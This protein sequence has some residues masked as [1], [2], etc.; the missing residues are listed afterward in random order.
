MLQRL[1]VAVLSSAADGPGMPDTVDQNLF[2]MF[3]SDIVVGCGFIGLG[4]ANVMVAV[5]FTLKSV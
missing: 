5:T 2:P 3:S 1:F 4:E